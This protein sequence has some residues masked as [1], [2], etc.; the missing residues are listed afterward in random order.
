MEGPAWALV[1]L[2]CTVVTVMLALIMLLSIKKNKEEED[3]ENEVQVMESEEEKEEDKN[4]RRWI[5]VLGII[6][7]VIAVIVFI[8]TEDIRLP[9]IIVDRWTWLMIVI[10]LVN[11]AVTYLTKY[12]VKR[13]DEEDENGQQ[14]KTVAAT[15]IIS[16]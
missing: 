4:R 16:E 11:L 15:A 3:E 8:L 7:A 13:E 6:P 9:M 1:N 10:L 12:R 5:K 14:L 2:I